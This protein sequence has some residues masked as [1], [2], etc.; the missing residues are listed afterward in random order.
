MSDS[1]R[2]QPTEDQTNPDHD[3]YT[4]PAISKA[5]IARAASQDPLMQFLK[6]QWQN[7][8][9]GIALVA[10]GVYLYQSY[11][12]SQDETMSKAAEL[13][14]QV[15][16]SMTEVDRLQE[17]LRAK[18]KEEAKN[19]ASMNTAKAAESKITESKDGD[20]KVAD[21]N[22]SALVKAQSEL[23]VEKD[24]LTQQ[25]LSLQ[26]SP[27]PYDAVAYFFQGL[28]A[29]KA[30]D[31]VKGEAHFSKLPGWKGEKP[32]DGLYGMFSE[33]G[34]LALA[35]AELDATDL[36]STDSNSAEMQKRA[37]DRLERLVKSGQYAAVAAAQT[38]V[39]VAPSA[40][41]K[42]EAQRLITELL[43]RQPEQADLL[44]DEIEQ[45]TTVS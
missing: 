12:T 24:R 5:A 14:R 18:E 3:I 34:E 9:A 11:R 13:F 33:Y 6:L 28:T 44:K 4:D 19:V 39:R 32:V 27:A 43:K 8:V 37:F 35:K 40:E 36:S 2:N 23:Q 31:I 22:Q 25:L 20:G 30:G 10:I 41:E 38:L 16:T 7:I 45:L 21:G 26:D 15:R 1:A 42:L 29:V 17:N